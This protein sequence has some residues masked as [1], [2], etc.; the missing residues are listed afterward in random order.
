MR[1]VLLVMVV[2]VVLMLGLA[3]A[4]DNL[5]TFVPGESSFLCAVPVHSNVTSQNILDDFRKLQ[6]TPS[7][8]CHAV[9]YRR[10]QYIVR[11]NEDQLYELVFSGKLTERELYELIFFGGHGGSVA[12]SDNAD[13]VPFMA[14]VR[15]RQSELPSSVQETLDWL[16]EVH[17]W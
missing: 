6:Y 5:Y 8:D 15:E 3:V 7:G 9:S 13:W 2:A 16:L 1:R 14:R 12:K 4:T 10:L 17:G 11:N